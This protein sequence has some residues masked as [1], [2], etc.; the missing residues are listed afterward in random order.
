MDR[1]WAEND[2]SRGLS[3]PALLIDIAGFEGPLD[4]LLHLARNQKV[5]LSRISILAL[6]EQYL[7]FIYS[8]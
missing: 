3:E 6:A 7:R 5:D 2:D 4:L 8:A 1:L